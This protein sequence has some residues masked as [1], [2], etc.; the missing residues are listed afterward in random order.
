MGVGSQRLAPA[1]L[2]PGET[3]YSVTVQVVNNT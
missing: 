2:R 3:R 1:A